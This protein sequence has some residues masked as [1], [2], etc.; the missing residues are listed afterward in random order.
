M[1]DLIIHELLSKILFNDPYTNAHNFFDSGRVIC[2]S[3]IHRL[4]PPHD[5]CSAIIY[6]CFKNDLQIILVYIQHI[7]QDSLQLLFLPYSTI[8]EDFIICHLKNRKKR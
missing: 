8:I 1:P 5:P 2:P 6:S 4:F 3:M 7:I